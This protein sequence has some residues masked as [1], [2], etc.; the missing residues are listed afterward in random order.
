[1]RLLLL[2]IA[3]T[4]A[5]TIAASIAAATTITTVAAFLPPHRRGRYEYYPRLPRRLSQSALQIE[6]KKQ[7]QQLLLESWF[8]A[9]D[10]NAVDVTRTEEQALD[11]VVHQIQQKLHLVSTRHDNDFEQRR[12]SSGSSSS[13]SG[14]SPVQ[15][16]LVAPHQR[17]LVQGRF[18]DLCQTVQGEAVLEDLLM[19]TTTLDSITRWTTPLDDSVVLGGVIVLQSLCIMA[20]Q[21]GLK[22]TPEQLQRLVA[23]LDS[24]E[25]D[26]IE[27]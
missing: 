13:S 5:N 6:A 18:L 26:K 22:G 7:Q 19:E 20:S 15:G 27:Y 10:D 9:S 1:M 3:A 11:W 2:V 4:I 16:V 8:P 14:G 12:N 21:V 17:A 24:P 23:H 25:E